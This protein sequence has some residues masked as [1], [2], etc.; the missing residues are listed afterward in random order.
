[1]KTKKRIENIEQYNEAKRKIDAYNSAVSHYCRMNKTN[2]I[3]CAIAQTF[4]FADEVDNDL[5]SA[6]EVYY[7]LNNLPDKYTLYINEGRLT[8]TTWTGDVLGVV[9]FGKQYRSNFGDIRVPVR[10]HTT[11]GHTYHGTY[12]K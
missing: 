8:A 9:W 2:A 3:P 11:N 12:Y 10:V 4:P 6:V 5:R 1:M 7:F